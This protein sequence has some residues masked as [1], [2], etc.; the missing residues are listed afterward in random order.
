VRFQFGDR[1]RVTETANTDFAVGEGAI[2]YGHKLTPEY[3]VHFDRPAYG[4]AWIVDSSIVEVA[5]RTQAMCS[6]IRRVVASSV[7]ASLCLAL[8]AVPGAAEPTQPTLSAALEPITTEYHVHNELSG[9][10]GALYSFDLTAPPIT[11]GVGIEFVRL[12]VDLAEPAG[13]QTDGLLVGTHLAIRNAHR[14]Q[15]QARWTFPK[16]LRRSAP[17]LGENLD[18]RALASSQE[19]ARRIRRMGG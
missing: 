4:S 6:S 11:G 18:L 9:D 5:S 14:G 8:H 16:S 7:A 19:K 2:L 15:E 1:V 12:A 10:A 3:L 17:G 13:Q